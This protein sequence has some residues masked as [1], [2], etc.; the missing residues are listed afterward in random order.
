MNGTKK[1]SIMNRLEN[2]VVYI[3]DGTISLFLTE[4]FH[5]F[6]SVDKGCTFV[7]PLKQKNPYCLYP[8]LECII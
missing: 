1:N 6:L 3:C 4:L 2:S 8:G 5:G 7:D